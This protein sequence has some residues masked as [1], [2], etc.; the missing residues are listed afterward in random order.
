MKNVEK[1]TLSVNKAKYF[2]IY[3]ENIRKQFEVMSVIFMKLE[4]RNK[5]L[6]NNGP[7]DARGRKHSNQRTIQR[8]PNLVI[9]KT[10]TITEHS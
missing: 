5:I 10:K 3:G 9:R 8:P 6:R 1:K 4:T 7:L 2:D